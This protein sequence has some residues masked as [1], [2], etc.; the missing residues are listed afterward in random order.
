MPGDPT[1]SPPLRPVH[2][3]TRMMT[4]RTI[5]A[6]ILRE[7]SSTHGRSPGGY[8]WMVLEPALGIGFLALIFSIGFRSPRLGTNFSIY[9]ATGLLPFMMFGSLSGAISQAVNFSKSLLAYPRVT[10]LDAIIARLILGTLTQLLV[11]VIILTA[12]L[13]TWDT[14]TTLELDRILL[15][16]SMTIAL[17]AGIGVLNCF[18]MTMFP[19]WQRTWGI[20]TRPLFLVS[21]VIILFEGIPKPYSTVLWY[22]PLI[23]VTGEMRG[24]FYLTY[25]AEYVSPI[26]VFSVSLICGLIG[27][28]FL[29]RYHR[30]MLER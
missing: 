8:L 17:A 4:G 10:Y 16:Y 7:M 12:I 26:Y 21:G 18:L 19:L 1:H 15:T 29:H 14:R 11:G 30:D 2:K 9:Y 28:V 5:V 25:E 22:N 24:A 13:S 20:I 23:H 3:K 27:L 6:L